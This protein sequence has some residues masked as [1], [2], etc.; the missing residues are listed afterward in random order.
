MRFSRVRIET[1]WLFVACLALAPA[2]LWAQ[3][4]VPLHPIRLP[5]DGPQIG[6][7][8]LVFDANTKD[9]QAKPFEMSAPFTFYVTNVW[10]NNIT[11]TEVKPSCGCTTAHMPATPWLLHPGESGAVEAKINLMG[12]MGTI[13]KTLTFHTSVGL[14]VATLRVMI[15]TPENAASAGAP[16]R[17]AAMARA[18]GDPQAIFKDDCARCHADKGREALGERLYVADCG[19]CHESSHRASVVPDLHALKQPTSLEYW[20]SIITFGKAHTMMPGF[21]ISQGGPLTDQQVASLAGYLDHVI[22]HTIAVTRS[23]S[24][25]S[26]SASSAN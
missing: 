24:A 12:K 14:R 26:P 3:S 9:Y 13:T 1:R 16:D 7:Q 21:A 8:T 10:T 20:K 23:E 15:P 22:S 6:G 4:N 2:R 11:I 5:G 18:A 17:Q 19:I 25:K